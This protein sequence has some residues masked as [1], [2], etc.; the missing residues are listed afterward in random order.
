MAQYQAVRPCLSCAA[1]IFGIPNHPNGPT[2]QRTERWT[3][4]HGHRPPCGHLDVDQSWTGLATRFSGWWCSE[5]PRGHRT[6]WTQ[7]LLK[8]CQARNKENRYI[9]SGERG[10]Q[11]DGQSRWG[12]GSKNAEPPP[13]TSPEK[14][15][16]LMAP[17]SFL[18]RSFWTRARRLIASCSYDMLGPSSAIPPATTWQYWLRSAKSEPIHLV[19]ICWNIFKNHFKKNRPWSS[20]CWTMAMV[21]PHW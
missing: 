21:Q 6:W 17:G 8:Q 15:W 2:A 20:G 1:V 19:G 11:M 12:G 4:K 13:P 16:N 10:K 18:C 3:S 7:H 9:D 14:L 5:S